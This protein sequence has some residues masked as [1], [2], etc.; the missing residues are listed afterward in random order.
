VPK[1]TPESIADMSLTTEND[2]ALIRL[3]AQRER[4]AFEI[5]YD[6]HAPTAYSLI[7]RIVRDRVIAEDVLQETF[8]QVWSKAHDYKGEGKVAA[9]LLRIARNRSIDELRRQKRNPG[10][11][12]ES[13]DS[14]HEDLYLMNGQGTIANPLMQRLGGVRAGTDVAS[15]VSR[16]LSRSQLHAAL[17][18]IPQEQRQCLE[19]AYF[20]GLSQQQIAD[21]AKVP[22]GTVK[23]RVRMGLAKLEHIL[24]SVGFRQEDVA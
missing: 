9:W 14:W 6:R 17:Q 19:L 4:Q 11:Q 15:E 20:E 12:V 8:W 21:H 22:L 2:E 5:L 13:L 3:V 18:S 7:L 16:H 1:Q 24:R 23:T 10:G